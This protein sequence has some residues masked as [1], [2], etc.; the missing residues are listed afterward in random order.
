MNVARGMRPPLLGFSIEKT[1]TQHRR[2]DFLG[3]SGGR[4]AALRFSRARG[5]AVGDSKQGAVNTTGYDAVAAVAKQA[6]SDTTSTSTV[7]VRLGTH[8]TFI[9][10]HVLR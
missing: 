4:A 3:F 2:A 8:R 7:T 6:A 9:H 5:R 1:L 10:V